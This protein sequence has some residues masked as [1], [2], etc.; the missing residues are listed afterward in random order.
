MK[1]LSTKATD[2]PEI[3]FQSF[4]IPP[5]LLPRKKRKMEK[6]F[7]SGY[8]TWMMYDRPLAKVRQY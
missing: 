6:V 8:C 7:P 3:V 2:Q 4:S 1:P 5:R